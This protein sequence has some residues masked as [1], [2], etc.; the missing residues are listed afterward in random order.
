MVMI[1][2][3]KMLNGKSS[4]RVGEVSNLG[5]TPICALVD[6]NAGLSFYLIKRP[7]HVV[8]EQL[9]QVEGTLTLLGGGE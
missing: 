3:K 6:F 5:S 7:G 4:I 2:A 9:R 8:M 1:L